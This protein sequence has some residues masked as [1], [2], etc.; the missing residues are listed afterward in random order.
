MCLDI[1][2]LKEE[3]WTLSQMQDSCRLGDA[4]STV[5]LATLGG[6]RKYFRSFSLAGKKSFATVL[7]FLQFCQLPC[8]AN[9]NQNFNVFTIHGGTQR[10]KVT[11]T[12][13]LLSNRFEA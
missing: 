4:H 10:L 9:G 5:T 11:L 2:I 1:F 6:A 13:N 3:T 12:V 8:M 7:I